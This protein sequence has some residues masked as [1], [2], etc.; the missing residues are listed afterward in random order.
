MRTI[1]GPGL[2]LS[3]FVADRPPFDSLDGLAGWASGL[4]FKAFQIPVHDRRL[5]DVERAASDDVYARE[6]KSR[7]AGHGIEIAELAAHR[8]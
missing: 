8:A 4:G 2:M 7:L 1:R 6:L 3:Q 5:I